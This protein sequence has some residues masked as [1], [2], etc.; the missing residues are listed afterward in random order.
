[1]S[2]ARGTEANVSV[3]IPTYNRAED[4]PRAVASVMEQTRPVREIIVVDDGSEDN[5]EGVVAELPGPIR[6]LWQ[7]NAGV[8]HAR[9]RGIQEAQGSIIAFLGHR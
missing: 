9:N 3:I 7:E 2:E 5:T 6:Y 1:M 4:L 8:S